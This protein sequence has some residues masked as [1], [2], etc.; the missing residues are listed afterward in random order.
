MQVVGLLFIQP[1]GLGLN[2]WVRGRGPEILYERQTDIVRWWAATEGLRWDSDGE[3]RHRVR[4]DGFPWICF[5][6][7]TALR[8]LKSQELQEITL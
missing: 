4:E 8:G 6:C 7:A 3:G 2:F 5:C 1:L